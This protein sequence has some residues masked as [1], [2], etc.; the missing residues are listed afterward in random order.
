MPFLPD[1]QCRDCY[2]KGEPDLGWQVFANGTL[3]LRA[4]CRKCGRY[5]KYVPQHDEDGNPTPWLGEAPAPPAV[6]QNES[7]P[8]ENRQVESA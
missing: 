4:E 7:A 5:I 8:V 1:L 6:E 2:H 3:H